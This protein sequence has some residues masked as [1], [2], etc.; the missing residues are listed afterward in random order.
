MQRQH[1]TYG[2]EFLLFLNKDIRKLC[3]DKFDWFRPTFLLLAI[4]FITSLFSRLFLTHSQVE[5]GFCEGIIL[6]SILLMVIITIAFAVKIKHSV[7]LVA[8]HSKRAEIIRVQL[9][10]K[11][12]AFNALFPIQGCDIK[13]LKKPKRRYPSLIRIAL[14][15]NAIPPDLEEP[16]QKLVKAYAELKA[17]EQRMNQLNKE[18]L[19]S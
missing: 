19:A 13:V 1:R 16:A 3:W 4:A 15:N 12:A 7:L 5:K 2:K 10:Q 8:H 11:I 6:I 14:D 17:E 9:E 18:R